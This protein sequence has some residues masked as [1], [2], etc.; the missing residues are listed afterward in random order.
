MNVVT[1]P[2]QWRGVAESALD[3]YKVTLFAYGQPRPRTSAT[4]T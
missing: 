4:A 1:N 3:G 2:A